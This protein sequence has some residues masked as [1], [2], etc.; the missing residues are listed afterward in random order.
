MQTLRLACADEKPIDDFDG[1]DMLNSPF[2][3]DGQKALELG[4][5]VEPMEAP[6]QRT[7]AIYVVDRY[8]AVNLVGQ[9][10]EIKQGHHDTMLT[11]RPQEEATMWFRP[12]DPYVFQVRLARYGWSWSG[13]FT[14]TTKGDIPV[15]LRNDYDNTV[16]FLV[17][18]VHHSGPLVKILFK[19]GDKYSPFRFENHSMETFKI[20]QR[21]QA[22]YTSLL[23]YHCCAYAWDEPLAPHQ[24]VVCIQRPGQQMQDDWDEVGCFSFDRIEALMHTGPAYLAMQIVTQG[25]TRVLQIRDTRIATASAAAAAAAAGAASAASP[26]WATPTATRNPAVSGSMMATL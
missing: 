7:K 1:D 5:R 23:P 9:T 10:L 8:A 4:I 15:R 3:R 16:F 26:I 18:T 17:V 6:F 13:K 12:D 21:G 20:K 24:F 11:L 25:P 14:I 2:V 22:P 19:N